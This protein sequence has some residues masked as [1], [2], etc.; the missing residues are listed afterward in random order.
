MSAEESVA[1][2][3]AAVLRNPGSFP[4]NFADGLADSIPRLDDLLRS[5]PRLP[6][7]FS[8]QTLLSRFL[9]HLAGGALGAAPGPERLILPLSRYVRWTA[10]RHYAEHGYYQGNHSRRHLHDRL[11]AAGND[12]SRCSSPDTSNPAAGHAHQALAAPRTPDRMTSEQE[13]KLREHMEAF[14]FMYTRLFEVLQSVQ[15]DNHVGLPATNLF[16]HLTKGK[17]K[18]SP[19]ALVAQ[20]VSPVPKSERPTGH[21]LEEEDE[22]EEDDDEDDEDDDDYEFQAMAAA[23]SRSGGFI[24]EQPLGSLPPLLQSIVDHLRMFGSTGTMSGA[25]LQSLA[26]VGSGGMLAQLPKGS[27]QPYP[28]DRAVSALFAHTVEVLELAQRGVRN[29]PVFDHEDSR[30][31][32]SGT[33]CDAIPEAHAV[34][35]HSLGRIAEL[36]YRTVFR[37]AAEIARSNVD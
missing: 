6:G 8:L 23:P 3:L 7:G 2:G 24:P 20:S 5:A 19:S 11:D 26:N 16:E 32:P 22:D 10:D 13:A 18:A 36:Q 30:T 12:S 15:R 4:F 27:N 31:L 37:P 33:L 35:M 29:P 21:R 14:Q 9:P 1:S 25:G 28:F 17:E 34:F